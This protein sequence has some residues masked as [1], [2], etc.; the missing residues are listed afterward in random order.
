V[1]VWVLRGEANP[2]EDGRSTRRSHLPTCTCT[3]SRMVIG[4]GCSRCYSCALWWCS[5]SALLCCAACSP[6]VCLCGGWLAGWQLGGLLLVVVCI[7]KPPRGQQRGRPPARTAPAPALDRHTTSQSPGQ[8]YNTIA[9][10]MSTET[11]GWIVGMD[12]MVD[13]RQATVSAFGFFHNIRPVL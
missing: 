12:W 1:L 3:I 9:I 8:S 6:A 7:A 4:L 5:R 10:T 2:P 11:G 13:G